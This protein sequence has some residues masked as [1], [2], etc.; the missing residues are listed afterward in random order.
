LGLEDVEVWGRGVDTMAFTPERRS[1]SLR[2]AYGLENTVIFLHVGRLAAEKGVDRIVHAFARARESLPAGAARL[3]IAG[4]GP[5]EEALRILAGPDV[6]FLGVLD[7]QRALPRLYAS[8]DAFLFSSLTE[9]LGLVVLEAMSSG[10][11]VIATPA[12]GVADH[13]RDEV[14]GIAVPPTDVD[15]MAKAIVALTLDPER[16]ARLAAGARTG[17]LHLDWEAELDRLDASYRSVLERASRQS[18]RRSRPTD[19]FEESATRTAP[20]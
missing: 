13:L 18:Q 10:L 19:I 2:G 9:T 17:A 5:A 4:A 11:P 14:N 6:L 16:R 8:A 7:R 15:A 20:V 12:G 1:L 3:I